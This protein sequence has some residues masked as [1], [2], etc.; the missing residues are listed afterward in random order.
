MIVTN[1]EWLERGKTDKEFAEERI[2][3]DHSKGYY[4]DFGGG[5]EDDYID[6]YWEAVEREIVWLNRKHYETDTEET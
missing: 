1:R 3:Y 2:K 5:D 4:G 6:D